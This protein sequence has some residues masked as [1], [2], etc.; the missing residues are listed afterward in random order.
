M[1]G[2]NDK[3]GGLCGCGKEL[4]PPSIVVPPFSIL[5]CITLPFLMFEK[6]TDFSQSCRYKY[7]KS[8]SFDVRG[9]VS[10]IWEN[11]NM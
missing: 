2:S 1:L 4:F 3:G 7:I 10:S 9:S 5:T 6:Y 8:S 11:G